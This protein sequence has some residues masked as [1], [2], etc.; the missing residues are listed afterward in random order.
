MEDDVQDLAY[1]LLLVSVMTLLILFVTFC[2]HLLGW[3]TM[4]EPSPAE[5][6]EHVGGARP[7]R[8]QEVPG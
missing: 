3:D 6:A 5:H 8:R 1:L 4:S 7:H 2:D